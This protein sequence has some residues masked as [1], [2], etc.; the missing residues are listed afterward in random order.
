MAVYSV[1]NEKGKD[2]YNT[3]DRLDGFLPI[4]SSEFKNKYKFD[5]EKI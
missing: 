5:V 2:V 3:I 4:I 1:H